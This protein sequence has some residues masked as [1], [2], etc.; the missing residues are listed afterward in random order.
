MQVFES[1]TGLGVNEARF[2][3]CHQ[4]PADRA[5][6]KGQYDVTELAQY[7]ADH[8]KGQLTDTHRALISVVPEEAVRVKRRKGGAASVMVHTRASLIWSDAMSIRKNSE[9]ILN[10]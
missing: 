7:L 10:H 8:L 9:I 2:S 4:E 5:Y 1:W 6:E 3:G